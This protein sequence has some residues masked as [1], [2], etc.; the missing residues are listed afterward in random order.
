MQSKF[1]LLTFSIYL[2]PR[3][4]CVHL[5]FYDL[6]RNKDGEGEEV[7]EKEREKERKDEVNNKMNLEQMFFFSVLPK[8]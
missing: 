8:K 6:K 3:S 7:K 4:T 1:V 2:L 5:F